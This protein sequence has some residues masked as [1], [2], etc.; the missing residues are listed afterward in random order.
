MDERL[1]F[2]F[3]RTTRASLVGAGSTK[4]P[5]GVAR[6][7]VDSRDT[8][9]SN[10]LWIADLHEKGNETLG[11]NLKWHKVVNGRF[12]KEVSQMGRE[13]RILLRSDNAR[14]TRRCRIH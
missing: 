1:V 10:L 2:S 7:L 4:H 13:A 8:G 11:P 12:H 9:R 5:L 3:A 6:I 14:L